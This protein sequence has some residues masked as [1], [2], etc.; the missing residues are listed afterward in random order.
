MECCREAFDVV[1]KGA[2]GAI[3]AVMTN[4]VYEGRSEWKFYVRRLGGWRFSENLEI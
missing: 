2:S 4:Q 1:N 3:K